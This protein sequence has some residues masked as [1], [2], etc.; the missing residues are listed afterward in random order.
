[1]PLVTCAPYRSVRVAQNALAVRFQSTENAPS[2]ETVSGINM[3]DTL[4]RLASMAIVRTASVDAASSA[5]DTRAVATVTAQSLHTPGGCGVWPSTIITHSTHERAVKACAV[6]MSAVVATLSEAT[7]R[8][9]DNVST[10]STVSS[11]PSSSESDPS[12]PMWKQLISILWDMLD[13]PGR[14]APVGTGAGVGTDAAESRAGAGAGAGAGAVAGA[15]TR[16]GNC[17]DSGACSPAAVQWSV[18]PP[19]KPEPCPTPV[20]AVSV[21]LRDCVSA[22]ELDRI[23][24]RLV[25]SESSTPC[26]TQDPVVAVANTTPVPGLECELELLCAAVTAASGCSSSGPSLTLCKVLELCALG[27]CT[28]STPPTTEGGA[29]DNV[30]GATSAPSDRE[31]PPTLAR[32][33]ARACLSHLVAWAVEGKAASGQALPVEVQTAALSALSRV[34]SWYFV[35]C[36]AQATRDCV[37]DTYMLARICRLRVPC[38]LVVQVLLCGATSPVRHSDSSCT[39]DTTMPLPPTC[40]LGSCVFPF[41]VSILPAAASWLPHASTTLRMLHQAVS[42]ATNGLPSLLVAAQ[43]GVAEQALPSQFLERLFVV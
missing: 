40:A 21:G 35:R 34:L 39:G 4:A 13:L 18:A 20:V 1:M 41:L 16:G 8:G 2:H 31:A 27:L 28:T 14:E 37:A 23:G 25:W 38:A 12:V 32:A 9:L 3:T 5:T 7:R 26:S 10:S 17:D 43:R 19:A 30:V 6:T 33:F 11:A 24:W 15:D 29:E 36:C 22:D 42:D